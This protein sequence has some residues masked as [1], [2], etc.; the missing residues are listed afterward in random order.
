[1]IPPPVVLAFSIV[2]LIMLGVV[3]YVWLMEQR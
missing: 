2:L 1:M 3:F